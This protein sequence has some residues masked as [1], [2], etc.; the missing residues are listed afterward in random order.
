MQHFS[1]VSFLSS[2]QAPIKNKLGWFSTYLCGLEE[3][4]MWFF[5]PCSL[6]QVVR[7]GG[8]DGQNLINSAGLIPSLF[9]FLITLLTAAGPW[10]QLRTLEQL[11]FSASGPSV[12]ISQWERDWLCFSHCRMSGWQW[13]WLR[14][15]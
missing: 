14:Q 15:R 1:G 10:G 8:R 9:L 5:Q 11:S 3:W 4:K 12:S 6:C 7:G 13:G 2:H